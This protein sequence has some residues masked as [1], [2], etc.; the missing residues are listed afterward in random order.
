MVSIEAHRLEGLRR[1]AA[2]I[3]PGQSLPV[4]KELIEPLVAAYLEHVLGRDPSTGRPRPSK[5]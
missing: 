3:Q 1:S 5:E 2:M 4:P